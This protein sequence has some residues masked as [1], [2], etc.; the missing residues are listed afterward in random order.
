M[1]ADVGAHLGDGKARRV[2]REDATR[3]DA[4]TYFLEDL[5]LDVELLENGLEHE[6][7]AGEVVVARRGGDERGQEARLAFVVA[8][9]RDLLGEV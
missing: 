1:D 4:L 3:G 2:G 9:L 8:A 7:A 6:V 5:A